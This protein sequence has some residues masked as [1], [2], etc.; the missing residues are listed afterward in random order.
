MP[1]K[2]KQ[3]ED[4]NGT[5]PVAKKAK[6]TCNDWDIAGVFRPMSSF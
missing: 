5:I 6:R 3:D 2:Y 4:R 1:L